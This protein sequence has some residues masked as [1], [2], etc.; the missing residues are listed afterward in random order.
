M[1]EPVRL[2]NMKQYTI[3]RLSNGSNSTPQQRVYGVTQSCTE[4]NGAWRPEKE[5]SNGF[6]A[7]RE[8]GDW[9]TNMS[10]PTSPNGTTSPPQM[11]VSPP[12]PQ[13]QV[14]QPRSRPSSARPKEKFI[15]EHEIEIPANGSLYDFSA[16]DM[17]TFLRHMGVEERIVNHV[18][19]KGL[20]GVKFSKLKDS[21]LES[22]SMKNPVICHFRDRSIREKGGKKKLPFML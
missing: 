11:H 19:K 17:S 13:H 15:P 10:P 12:T 14:H 20:D 5:R 21:D 18:Y 9:D 1:A 4:L 2:V 7:N 16:D 8:Y 22:L 6:L 3:N